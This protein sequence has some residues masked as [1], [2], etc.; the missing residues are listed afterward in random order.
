[1][2]SPADATYQSEKSR[3]Q[4]TVPVVRPVGET[5]QFSGIWASGAGAWIQTLTPPSSDPTFD[6]TGE[7]VRELYGVS[8][9]GCAAKHAPS[10]P[11]VAGNAP[12][13]SQEATW[14]IGEL[15][16]LFSA[17]A[18]APKNEWGYD[19]VGYSLQCDIE[20]YR[21]FGVT[22][23]GYTRDQFMQIRSPADPQDDTGW[24]TYTSEPNVVAADIEGGIVPF[25]KGFGTGFVHSK[26]GPNG[27]W[28]PQNLES[29]LRDCPVIIQTTTLKNCGLGIF[30]NP[31]TIGI[32]P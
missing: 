21:C 10:A 30:F 24:F 1:M 25:S 9:G 19:F 3:F 31:R 2:Q 22:P 18:S 11:P 26:R 14:T 5:T 7:T 12:G 29:H 6:F 16:G 23:C 28:T 17:P 32:R 13:N 4:V 15:K 8:L 27:A 20:S